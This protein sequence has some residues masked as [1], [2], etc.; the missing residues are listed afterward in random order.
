[1]ENE[2][3][4]QHRKFEE[5]L[6]YEDLQTIK[7][8]YIHYFKMTKLFIALKLKRDPECEENDKFRGVLRGLEY[9]IKSVRKVNDVKT[10][11][12]RLD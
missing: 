4:P 9:S 2:N 11:A 12:A 7:D 3:Y 1:M 5:T 10:L 8:F 6:D